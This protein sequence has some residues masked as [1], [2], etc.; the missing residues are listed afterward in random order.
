MHD[1]ALSFGPELQQDSLYNE[2]ADLTGA[3]GLPFGRLLIA[4]R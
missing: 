2:L 4:R 1:Y 3:Y